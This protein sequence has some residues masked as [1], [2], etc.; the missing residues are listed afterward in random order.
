M[1]MN[2]GTAIIGG[3]GNGLS[4]EIAD[5]ILSVIGSLG[6]PPGS[7]VAEQQ[8]DDIAQAIADA[9]I[10]HI[11]DNAEV[12][13]SVATTVASPIPVTTAVVGTVG[14]GGTTAPGVG[15]GTGTGAAGSSVF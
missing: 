10:D 8:I 14:T 5:N 2:A 9:V 7:I 6:V 3:G 11:T 12:L 15:T 13:T 4:Q 1:A